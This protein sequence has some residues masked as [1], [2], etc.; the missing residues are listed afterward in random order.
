MKADRWSHPG[1]ASLPTSIICTCDGAGGCCLVCETERET[2]LG[3]DD[4]LD[5]TRPMPAPVRTPE[6]YAFHARI[7]RRW[8]AAGL[9]IWL[10]IVALLKLF[11]ARSLTP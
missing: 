2:E 3:C 8:A 5:A 10:L 11:G 9:A 4:R 6:D 1:R 7:A